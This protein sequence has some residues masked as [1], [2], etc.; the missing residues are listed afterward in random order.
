MVAWHMLSSFNQPF[1]R[2]NVDVRILVSSRNKIDAGESLEVLHS[3]FECRFSRFSYEGS[4]DY[5][6]E[7]YNLQV[8]HL[9]NDGS[10]V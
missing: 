1:S 6:E 7:A 8:S 9:H 10:K 3:F 4:L 2:I 5:S